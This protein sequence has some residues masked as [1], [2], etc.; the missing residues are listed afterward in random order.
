VCF[1][2]EI[3]EM[4]RRQH[5]K[6]N[7]WPSSSA[8]THTHTHTQ[9]SCDLFASV[10]SFS[11]ACNTQRSVAL[12][13]HRNATSNFVVAQSKKKMSRLIKVTDYV[14]ARPDEGICNSSS[15]WILQKGLRIHFILFAFKFF[16]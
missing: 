11:S 12:K 9:R 7:E 2:R 13:A 10:V 4:N 3:I 6:E 14:E 1:N 5:G 16:A 15:F 8:Q